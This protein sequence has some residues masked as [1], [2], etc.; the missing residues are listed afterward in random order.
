MKFT[1]IGALLVALV[2]IGIVSF[3]PVST[4]FV[5]IVFLRDSPATV[6]LHAH[7][8]LQQRVH[9]SN[10]TYSG[11]GIFS[12]APVLDGRNV[13]VVIRDSKGNTVASGSRN[14]P[15]Y[16]PTANV[17][18]LEIPVSWFI[19]R[20]DDFYVMDIELIHGDSIPLRVMARDNNLPAV[21]KLSI[22]NTSQNFILSLYFMKRVPAVPGLQSGMFIG[23]AFLL[24]VALIST[25]RN[26]KKKY[27][28]AIALIIVFA[29]LAVLGYW[30][31][32]GDLGIAD[33]DFYFTLHDSYR[34]AILEHHT[35][36]FWDPYI[37]GGTAGL[38][39]PEFP[40]FSP[41]FLL[42]FIF[43]IPVG[44]KLAITLSV[45]VGATGMLTLARL[46]GRS[47][48]AGLIAAL[49]VA[50]GTVSLLEITEGHVNVFAA[51]WIPWIL[52]S[53]LRMY[54]GKGTPLLCA[55]FLALTFLGGGIYLLMYT[56]FAFLALILLVREHRRAAILT[57]KSGLWAL[58]L[59]SFKLVPVLLWLRQFPDDA[60]ASSAYT[61]PWLV[62]ILFGRYLHG[63][64]II[65][66]QASGWHEYGAYIGYIVGALAILGISR[67]RKNRIVQSLVLVSVATLLI[68]AMGPSLQVVFDPLWFFPRSNISRLILFSVIPL[69][70]LAAYGAD[71]IATVFP[72]RGKMIRTLLVGIVAIDIISLTYQVSEQAFILPHVVPTVSPAPSP[73]AFTPERYDDLGSGS[74]HTRSYDAYKVGYGTLVY[75]S[76]LGPTPGVR[77][78]YDEG[79]NGAV[80]AIDHRANASIVSW[81]YNTVRVHVDTPVETQVVLNTNYVDGWTVSAGDLTVV[82]NRVA[83]EVKPGSYDIVFSYT[84][85]GFRTGLLI[86]LGTLAA[87]LLRTYR[88]KRN[89]QQLTKFS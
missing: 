59:V 69:A 11:V 8:H 79:D 54:R 82:S 37:C 29:P 67:I 33:W 57:V 39:D 56:A 46:L 13:R 86:T 63:A 89:E 42:E 83:T 49:A 31:S 76:V 45:I 53:W 58:G 15:S 88:A 85:P 16:R 36:P 1:L 5:R 43:G 27:W 68:S 81:N 47:V 9:L 2:V 40:L 72:K 14:N 75:C 25:I 41:T 23:V 22:N 3:A 73:I 38:G 60:Y 24:A 64:Y 6:T 74:R 26:V 20:H 51:M 61:L 62:D 66:D 71:R 12:D 30:I 77:T 84:A 44:V 80:S 50:F 21:H 65:P 34:K 28:A 17:M 32:T 70:L 55:L 48:E 7:E 87:L 35:F 19:V 10:G 18:Q 78:I 4:E 52:W